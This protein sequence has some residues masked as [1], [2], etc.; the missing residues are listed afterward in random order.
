MG[1]TMT[2]DVLQAAQSAFDETTFYRE[3]YRTRP[4]EVDDLAF[5]SHAAYHRATGLLGCIADREE[6]IGAIAPWLRGVRRFPYTIVESD[7]ES[8]HRFNRFVHALDVLGLRGDSPRKFAVVTDDAHGPWACELLKGLAWDS[9]QASMTYIEN[10]VE[11]VAADI[12]ALEPDC[13]IA[14]T[15]PGVY[16]PPEGYPFVQ[17]VHAE[18]PAQSAGVDQLLTCDELHIFAARKKGADA[19]TYD[20]R[21]LC[22]EQEPHSKLPA[23]TT[24]EYDVFPLVRYVLSAPPELRLQA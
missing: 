15:E 12:A 22:V 17:A 20:A 16:S 7:E 5:V 8:L 11:A 21:S 3:L 24:T 1:T 14:A 10:G 2:D 19:F 6:I 9:H 18:G 4:E 13:V 23:I